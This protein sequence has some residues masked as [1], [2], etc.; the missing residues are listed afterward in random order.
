M[1]AGASAQGTIV[2]GIDI[3]ADPEAA[4]KSMHSKVR[5]EK[6]SD[7]VRIVIDGP[8][9]KECLTPVIDPATGRPQP[10]PKHAPGEWVQVDAATAAA[11]GAGGAA[12]PVGAEGDAAVWVHTVWRHLSGKEQP[13]SRVPEACHAKDPQTGNCPIHIAAQNGHI[14]IV[15]L[16]IKG[17]CDVNAQN[18]GGQTAMHMAVAYD[19][20]WTGQ[21]LVAAGG[22]VALKNAEGFEAGK[23]IE[24]DKLL[25]NPIAAFTSARTKLQ[26]AAAV[27]LVNANTS[28]LDK[29]EYVMSLMQKKRAM[30]ADGMGDVFDKEMNAACAKVMRDWDDTAKAQQAAAAASG[31]PAD[32]AAAAAAANGN[33]VAS[34]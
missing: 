14:D 9:V 24:G 7:L 25:N 12:A 2:D 1:G 4:T 19:Y 11:A 20:F 17:G 27:Q 21:V 15:K 3:H 6:E 32:E 5:W 28:K 26:V 16:L 29:A 30:K 8:L 13:W 33:V 18:N 34:S 22:D 10:L 31:A 23:G